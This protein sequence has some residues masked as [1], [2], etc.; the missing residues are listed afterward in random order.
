M[1]KKFQNYKIKNKKIKGQYVLLN[2]EILK[3]S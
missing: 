1:F 3:I 2:L